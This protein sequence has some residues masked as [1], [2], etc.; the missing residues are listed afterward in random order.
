MRKLTKLE[1]D[2]KATT[3]GTHRIEENLFVRVRVGRE[4]PRAL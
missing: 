2:R 4:G 3:I 1:I